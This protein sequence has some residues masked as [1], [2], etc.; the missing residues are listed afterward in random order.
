MKNDDRYLE[1]AIAAA[2][3]AGRIQKLHFG[4]FHKVEYKGEIDPVSEIDKLCE[5]AVNRI[6][7]D[8]FPDHDVLTEESAFKGK[9]SPWKW[10][11]DPIDGT[12]NY[13]HG[14]PFFC[15]SIGLEVKGEVTLGVVYDPILDQLFNAL[16]GEGAYLNGKRIFVS[17][18]NNLGRSFLC[19]GFPYDI[20]EHTDFYLRYF[21]QFITKSVAIRRPGSAA[22]DL[23]YVGAGRFDGFW[24]L[25]LHAW[26][27]AA[28]SL[29]ITE[30][31][32]KV[33]D[34]QGGPFNIYSEEILASNGLIHQEMLRVIQEIT[35]K[36]GVGD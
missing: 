2:K 5:K 29:I 10:I 35:T 36:S 33:T 21:R 20:R 31:G 3:E 18:V 25:K 26:D 8:A 23:C 15:V 19:T 32:G 9:G 34:F 22:L 28:A 24:E 4:H 12:T 16:K 13:I 6:I 7:F 1:V 17:Q 14:F 11:I 30:A 27:V